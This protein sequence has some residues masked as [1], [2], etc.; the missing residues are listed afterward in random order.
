MP[1]WTR[2]NGVSVP[3]PSL[4][5]PLTSPVIGILAN[6]CTLTAQ[7]DSKERYKPPRC[8][9]STRENILKKLRD[10]VE[11]TSTP[12][13]TPSPNPNN[14]G[15]PTTPNP[16]SFSSSFFWLHG[17]AGAGKSALAQSLAEQLKESNNLAASFFFFS[18]EASR[19]NGDR[20][21]PTIIYQLTRIHAEYEKKVIDQLRR[22]Q[23][24]FSRPRDQQM[25]VLFTDPLIALHSERVD[26]STFPRL[27]VIDGLDECK[28]TEHQSEILET[29]AQIILCN[30]PYH[31]RFLVASRPEGH[32]NRAFDTNKFIKQI[33]VQK[34][35]LSKD[36]DA[37]KDIR[38]FLQQ[39][40]KRL[41]EVHAIGS[42]LENQG[43]P[44]ETE[45]SIVIDRSSGHFVYPATVIRYIESSKHRPD[46]RLGIVLG[47]SPRGPSDQPFSQ[48]DA[49]YNLILNDVDESNFIKIKRA[50][51]ILYL[52]S[53]KV[54]Y[55]SIYRSGSSRIIQDMLLLRPGDLDLLF[56][57]LR[58]LVAQESEEENLHVFHKTL[59]DFLLDPGRSQHFAVSKKLCHESAALYMH[60][61]DIL[62]S[63]SCKFYFSFFL[64]S[65]ATHDECR[66]TGLYVLCLSLLP[67][68]AY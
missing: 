63:W 13:P 36:S 42:I 25:R 21:F 14:T 16:N 52:I 19:N 27:I 62:T 24:I 18:I 38:T 32:I 33:P 40:F 45:L 8:A 65:N 1:R 58:S 59:F 56:D 49:L 2:T 54:G 5:S 41:C 50:F 53:E 31:F 46:D 68:P 20:L 6:Q 22:N 44:S 39:E 34:Y 61:T 47:L 4:R 51:S 66:R 67:C 37:S 12:T 57:P 26:P 17:G 29:I 15:R 23:D 30:L 35:D 9:E 64:P 10:W 43:W 55:F 28:D 11:A 7:F 60:N 48:L 3:Q